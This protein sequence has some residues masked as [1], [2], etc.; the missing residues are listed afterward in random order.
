MDLDRLAS[1]EEMWDGSTVLFAILNFWFP[2]WWGLVR[3]SKAAVSI[4]MAVALEIEACMMREPPI[5][6]FNTSMFKAF[7]IK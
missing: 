4:A 3:K 6:L 2:R 1:K 5:K 7:Y